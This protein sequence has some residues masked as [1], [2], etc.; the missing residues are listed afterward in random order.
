MYTTDVEK[1]KERFREI[2]GESGGEIR[3]FFAPGR[4]NLIGGHTGLNGGHVFPCTVDLGVYGAVRPRTDRVVR[5]STLLDDR[6]VTETFSLDDDGFAAR[7]GRWFDYPKGVFAALKKEGIEIPSG[8]DI[9]YFGDLPVSVGL[10]SSSALEVLTIYLLRE[11][12]GI[13]DLDPVRIAGIATSVQNDYMG[14][15]SGIMDPFTSAV[16]RKDCGLL[17]T[18][19]TLRC[20][21]VPLRLGDA[22][23]ILTW[24][25]R[26]LMPD[27]QVYQERR[28]DCRKALTKL[29]SIV[30]IRHLCDLTWD[31]FESC[32]DVIMNDRY[33]KRARHVIY[34]DARTIRAVSSLRVG[35]IRRFGEIMNQ[36]FLSMKENYE[37]TGPEIDYLA[38]TS[39][40]VPGVYGCRMTGEGFG[41]CL[42]SIVEAGA[43]ELFREKVGAACKERFGIDA[44][45]H[46]ASVVDGVREITG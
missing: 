40:N 29:Q 45:F 14:V 22:R 35:N 37:I 8:A 21:Y 15:P 11:L 33:T 6:D 17:L 30:H 3:L 5:V 41:G 39:M 27:P 7:D 18:V 13:P 16:G 26:R 1:L 12:Y 23:I 28:E 10:S 46:T 20:E 44:K 34:E 31:R 32:K 36:S 38:E 24:T 42:V 25:G 9:L 43:E 2:Y 4:V 19:D